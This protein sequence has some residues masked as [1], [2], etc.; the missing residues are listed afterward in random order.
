M[1]KSILKPSIAVEN[2]ILFPRMLAQNI[3]GYEVKVQEEVRDGVFAKYSLPIVENPTSPNP[4][5]HKEVFPYRND[6][7]Y[8][9]PTETYYSPDHYIKVY[10]NGVLT[11]SLYITFND[12]TKIL[13]INLSKVPVD[14]NDKVELEYY[15]DEIEVRHTAINKCLYHVEPVLDKRYMTGKHS[16]LR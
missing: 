10:I 3:I 7:V 8:Q 14:I 2:I 6:G 15:K 11:P 16:L 4:I 12:N 9:L 13:R 1:S 5:L